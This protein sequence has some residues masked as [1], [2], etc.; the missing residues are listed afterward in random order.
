MISKNSLV[1]EVGL[2]QRA[3][4]TLLNQVNFKIHSINFC[5][6]ERS[7]TLTKLGNH[8][9]GFS[10][11]DWFF[12]AI[13]VVLRTHSIDLSE[14]LFAKLSHLNVRSALSEKARHCFEKHIA[15]ISSL[16]SFYHGLSK[17]YNKN[18]LQKLRDR[19]HKEEN[20]F[21][22]VMS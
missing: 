6:L 17:F 12:K 3:L 13:W 16:I 19:I 8:L 20:E 15:K 2:L 7:V 22:T 4:K 5:F 18:L 10:E 14:W 9:S 1:Y 11:S 21:V